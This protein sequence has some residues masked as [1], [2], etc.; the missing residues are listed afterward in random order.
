[1][2]TLT[3]SLWFYHK[4]SA[5]SSTILNLDVEKSAVTSFNSPT[6]LCIASRTVPLNVD[7]N[8]GMFC[9]GFCKKSVSY[10]THS[11]DSSSWILNGLVSNCFDK[12]WYLWW[13]KRDGK[14]HSLQTSGRSNETDDTKLEESARVQTLHRSDMYVVVISCFHS[15]LRLKT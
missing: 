9:G 6:K 13:R 11:S 3:Y 7:K 15:T 5:M 12:C 14:W 1:M 10:N 2:I 4:H 8:G